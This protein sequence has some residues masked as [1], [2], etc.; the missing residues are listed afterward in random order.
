[1]GTVLFHTTSNTFQ[2][3]KLNRKLHNVL[4]L[5]VKQFIEY[6][7]CLFY[8]LIKKICLEATLAHHNT[9]TQIK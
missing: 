6:L 5:T 9:N 8:V 1:M 4:S 3:Y 2:N 7:F